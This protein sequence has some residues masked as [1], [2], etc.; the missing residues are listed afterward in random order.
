MSP[1][2]AR[3]EDLDARTDLFS[4]GAVLYEMATGRQAFDGA[5]S[6]VVFDAILNREP[7]AP[8]SLNPELPR[9]FEEIVAKSLEKNRDLRYQTAAELR[10][11]LKRLERDTDS[12]RAGT[13]AAATAA[14]SAN[15]PSGSTPV[16]APQPISSP[17]FPH[18]AAF[19]FAASRP[20]DR[21]HP[22]R[23]LCRVPGRFWDSVSQPLR[24][25]QEAIS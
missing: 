25:Q 17:A 23:P 11:D 7:V 18:T 6:A 13:V 8:S 10:T 9:K 14:P 24:P 1:E 20:V 16:A 21:P 19:P 22:G 3:G 4:L 2:Q 5:T 12:A 15:P